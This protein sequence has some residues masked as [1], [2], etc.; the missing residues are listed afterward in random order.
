MLY[1]TKTKSK[2]KSKKKNYHLNYGDNILIIKDTKNHFKPVYKGELIIADNDEPDETD[3]Y[4]YKHGKGTIYL[5]FENVEN[6]DLHVIETISS[7]SWYYDLPSN[8]ISI[9]FVNKPNVYTTE[10]DKCSICLGELLCHD[11]NYYK[12]NE[13][14]ENLT[15]LCLLYNCGHF[16]H[17]GCIKTHIRSKMVHQPKCPVC[18]TDIN[19]LTDIGDIGSYIKTFSNIPYKKGGKS[20]KN[21]P[22]R[23]KYT[24]KRRV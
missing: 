12:H 23:K 18:N 24:K 4:I 17:K 20:K 14:K 16:F 8:D 2:A 9:K 21:K 13:C 3:E 6:A 15:N 5:H 10:K 19:S 22:I 11:E 1:K 7:N